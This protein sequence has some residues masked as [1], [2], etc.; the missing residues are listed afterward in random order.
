[1]I[2]E[3]FT[4][5]LLNPLVNLLVLLSHLLFNSFG[6]AIIAFTIL[7]RAATFPLT[8]RQ[9]HTTKAMQSIQPKIQEINKKYSDPKRRQEEV[10]KLYRESGTNPLSCIGPFFLQIPIFIAL[11]SAI[12]IA[13]PNSPEAL[14]KL[15]GHIYGWSYLQHALPLSEHFLGLDLRADGREGLGIIF[16]IA[17]AATTWLQSKTTITSTTDERVR[18]QQQMTNVLLP[19]MFAYFAFSFPIGVS[20]YWV[21]NSTAQIGFNILTYGFPALGIEPVFKGR[22]ATPAA[23][24]AALTQPEEAAA[25]TSAR[26][27][28]TANGP[29]R[30]KRQNRRRRP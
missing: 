19:F 14:E 1:V 30:S 12:R 27:L 15:S 23:P 29:G 13:L 20:L 6:L 3:V 28:R 2:S 21:V 17:V 5:I 8:L 4:L 9:I 11:Y 18:Q 10:M 7:I 25:T 26:E 24:K 22:A 16:V